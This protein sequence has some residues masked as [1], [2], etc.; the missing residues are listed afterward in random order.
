MFVII[1][2]YFHF[3]S[4][5]PRKKREREREYWQINIILKISSKFAIEKERERKFNSLLKL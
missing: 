4:Q 3:V 1:F 2:Y 5:E